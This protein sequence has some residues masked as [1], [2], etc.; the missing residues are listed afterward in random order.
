M[1]RF[2]TFEWFGTTDEVGTSTKNAKGKPN[3]N[4]QH[5]LEEAI[6]YNFDYDITLKTKL[7]V[8]KK[9]VIKQGKLLF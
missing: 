8:K 6:P 2:C 5:I 7:Q 4:K 1:S 3:K 9:T